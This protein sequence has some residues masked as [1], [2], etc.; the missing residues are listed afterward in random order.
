MS[1]N[2]IEQVLA[3]ALDAISSRGRGSVMG[4]ALPESQRTALVKL[5]DMI[6]AA[7]V[8]GN[9]DAQ[10]A[11]KMLDDLIAQG[12]GV[13]I[14]LVESL[15]PVDEWQR[16][17]DLRQHAIFDTASFI[18]F[19][20]RYGTAEKSLVMYSAEKCQLVIDELV[21]RGDREI[22]TFSF[23]SSNDFK[24]WA[25]AQARKMTHRDLLTLLGNQ[26]HNLLDVSVIEPLRTLKLKSTVAHD[27]DVLETGDQISVAFQTGGTEEIKKF[28]RRF[29][30]RLPVFD[31]DV[32]H[33]EQ[34]I[35][36]EMRLDLFLP[37]QAGDPP[38]FA[39]TCSTWP[40]VTRRRAL[41][42]GK[43]ITDGLGG[44][45]SVMHGQLANGVRKIGR[46]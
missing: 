3:K 20:K 43:V 34:W 4:I 38:L 13:E 1:Q 12:D 36:A 25:A 21:E 37:A 28:K 19:A 45:W 14:R 40:E 6:A 22:I 46:N 15:K 32:D 16:P 17:A 9:E 26:E 42:E 44:G 23:H 27:S 24:A 2:K 8:D 30:V 11:M 5:H 10:N 39:L 31:L 33:K 7:A 35:E 18:A 29:M 41:A